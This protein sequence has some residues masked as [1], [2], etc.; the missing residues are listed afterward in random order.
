MVTRVKRYFLEIK[1]FSNPIELNIPKNYQI[2]LDDKKDFK[3]NKF[4]YK[5]IG[6]DHYWRDR[7]VWSDKEWLQYLKNKDLETH[8]DFFFVKLL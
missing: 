1:N 7:L 8:I 5:Q 3:L 4:F 6:E 2:I